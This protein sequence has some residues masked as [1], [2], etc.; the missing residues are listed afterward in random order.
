MIF[1]KEYFHNVIKYA[2]SSILHIFNNICLVRGTSEELRCLIP[3]YFGMTQD[4]TQQVFVDLPKH[5]S[6]QCWSRS[7]KIVLGNEI[8]CLETSDINKFKST[9]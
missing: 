6:D 3:D 7:T 4:N 8:N 2:Q 5:I 1:R 9:S